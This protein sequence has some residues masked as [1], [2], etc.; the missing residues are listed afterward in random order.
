MWTY[1]AHGD[2]C[3]S[4]PVTDVGLKNYDLFEGLPDCG[5]EIS[6]LDQL[7]LL[8]EILS[9]LGSNETVGSLSGEFGGYRWESNNEVRTETDRRGHVISF[10]LRGR[11]CQIP[12][13]LSRLK[14]LRTLHLQCDKI[15]GGIPP[16]LANLDLLTELWVSGQL[17]TIPSELSDM[18]LLK[19]LNLGGNQLTGIPS[20]L[21]DL[22][23]LRLLNLWSNQL[24]SIPP[25][26]GNL[27]SLE[28]L[29][30]SNNQLSG[31]IPP[32]LGALHNLQ[33]LG[34]S[35]NQLTA[36]PPEL[37]N[38]TN[39][40][41][42]FSL[43]NNQ[44]SGPIPPELAKVGTSRLDLS[45]N[46]FS[47]PIPPEL[48]NMQNVWEVN[49]SNNRLTG[50]IPEELGN[51]P[52]LGSLILNGNMLTGEIPQFVIDSHTEPDGKR[53][54]VFFDDNDG[55]CLSAGVEDILLAKGAQMEG[56]SC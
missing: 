1:E 9:K 37:G 26:L 38:L 47:G 24:T 29:D 56:P 49:L 21:G 23:N 25:E 14:Y 52:E 28:Y 39:I 44:L 41:N 12:A 35:N 6:E 11:D 4:A 10:Q 13:E 17:T 33:S 50:P 7:L 34:L 32:E 43:N 30:I 31:P 55:L 15:T 46:Q 48:G 54:R 27:R 22:A 40:L 19:H 51:A 8:N 53:I 3:A 16:E 45:N 42:H 2:L 20:E 36:V 5:P 18:R